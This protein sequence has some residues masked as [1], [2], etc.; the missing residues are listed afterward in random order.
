MNIK[1]KVREFAIKAHMGQIRKSEPDK[2]LSWEERKEHTICETKKLPFRNKLVV[3]A[4][5]I[6]NLE[7][8]YLKFKKSGKR[9]FSA[10]RR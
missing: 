9:D 6:N 4:D 10:F 2:S 1:D 5:K 7:N 3:C 8:L